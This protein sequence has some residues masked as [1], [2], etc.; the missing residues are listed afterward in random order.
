[1]FNFNAL[2]KIHIE[3]NNICQASCPMCPRNMHGGLKNP[4]IKNSEWTVDDFKTILV[5][6]VLNSIS[7]LTICGNFGEPILNNDLIPMLDYFKSVAPNTQLNLFTNGSARSN[8]WWKKLAAVLPENHQVVFALDGFED[9][10]HLYRVGTDFNKIINNAKILIGE[11]K[12]AVWSFIRFKHNQHQVE[13]AKK[14]SKELGFKSFILKDTRRFTSPQLKVVDR[15]GNLTHVLEQAEGS[16]I[17]FVHKKDLETF[18]SWKKSTELNCFANDIKEIFIDTYH[19]VMPCCIQAAFLYTNYNSR[20]ILEKYGLY[21]EEYASDMLG[22][23]LQ[24]NVFDFVNE[25]GGFEKI[26]AKSRGL[27]NILESKEWNTVL[28]ER[29][30][31]ER[32][33][34]CIVMCSSDSPFISI[35]GQLIKDNNY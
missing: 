29:W 18:K 31:S 2:D 6:E 32:S 26:N 10:H 15:K 24:K 25:L 30:K 8:A 23:E 13:D 12:N 5:P 7:E 33:S 14:F 19:H 4:L 9:T 21:E 1:M 16:V 20:E 17:K 27:I 22:L 28:K 11:G 35:R 3:I 34:C